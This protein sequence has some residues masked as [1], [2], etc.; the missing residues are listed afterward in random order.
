[1]A[2]VSS[3]QASKRNTPLWCVR[4]NAYTVYDKPS[5]SRMNRAR[6]TGRV[7]LKARHCVRQATFWDP[8]KSL[9][10]ANGR[11]TIN[12]QALRSVLHRL[13]VTFLP[14]PNGQGTRTPSCG[15][16]CPESAYYS[17]VRMYSYD[18]RH[19]STYIA[20]S[21]QM[22]SKMKKRQF[23]SAVKMRRRKKISQFSP[24]AWPRSLDFETPWT[25]ATLSVHV[26]PWYA[27]NCSE[28][29]Q[30]SRT[31]PSRRVFADS[32]AAYSRFYTPW[33]SA[34]LSMHVWPW[35]AGN[36]SE[37]WKPSRTLPSRRVFAESSAAYSRF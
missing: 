1:L 27:G 16:V 25:S 5:A 35:Y 17:P 4:V 22:D 18:F 26:S 9:H 34:T 2:Q 30:A 21:V 10:R 36:C 15:Q 14:V 7:R 11:H 29:W 3:F 24:R 37:Y 13:S 33:T 6:L 23:K 31:L 12:G 20:R 8:R 19:L 28:Y 32:S